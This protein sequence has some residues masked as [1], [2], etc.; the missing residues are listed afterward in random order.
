VKEIK[1]LG[2]E[3]S[4][5][6][7]RSKS[8]LPKM[9]EALNSWASSR[10]EKIILAFDEAQLLNGFRI[11]F[12]AI[13]AYAYDYLDSLQFI[14]TGSEVGLLYDFLKIND[15]NSP[16]YG[17]YMEEIRL[18]RL[19]RAIE[20][21]R[22]GFREAGLK[23]LDEDLENAVDALDGV[24]GWLSY[25]GLT[26]IRIGDTGRKAL[27]ATLEIGS[28][29]VYEE[30]SKLL[31]RLN[32]SKYM[33]ILKALAVSPLRWSEIKNILVAKYGVAY[34]KNLSN[35]LS[36]L[37]KTG[38]VVKEDELYRIADPVYQYALRKPK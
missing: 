5:D 12:P 7:R 24:I 36:K 28:K 26:S 22:L 23:P 31:N 29:I 9:L 3:V 6:P 35:L 27:E 15:P 17:R 1:I 2:F 14:L 32:S 13:F 11:D 10:G 37:I 25:Y 19:E 8:V 18:K 16:L 34:D 30:V 21:L 4:I 33:V 38:I 20:F